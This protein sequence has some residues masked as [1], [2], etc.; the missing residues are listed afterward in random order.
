MKGFIIK[1]AGK[2]DLFLVLAPSLAQA[3][4]Q[5]IN[6]GMD[7]LQLHDVV[8]AGQLLKITVV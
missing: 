8:P 3:Y 7:N 6:T 1:E 5:A 2:A 4:Q